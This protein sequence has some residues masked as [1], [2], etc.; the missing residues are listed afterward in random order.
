[1]LKI[2]KFVYKKILDEINE[3][4]Q[5]Q[6]KFLYD[7]LFKYLIQQTYFLLDKDEN[8]IFE[9]NKIRKNKEINKNP[10]IK[11]IVFEK[12]L[13]YLD[14]ENLSNGFIYSNDLF[15]ELEKIDYSEKR[16]VLLKLQKTKTKI[17]KKYLDFGLFKYINKWLKEY[18]DISVEMCLLILTTIENFP[19]EKEM[20]QRQSDRIDK[21]IN[22]VIKNAMSEEVKELARRVKKRWKEIL[23]DDNIKPPI[24]NTNQNVSS[25]NSSKS[26][27]IKPQNI[28]LSSKPKNVIINKELPKIVSYKP[29]QT[30]S[31]SISSLQNKLS[32]SSNIIDNSTG[33]K[34]K[35]E[36]EGNKTIKQAKVVNNDIFGNI[37]NKTQAKKEVKVQETKILPIPPSPILPKLVMPIFEEKKKV[38][39]IY[40]RHLNMFLGKVI[41]NYVNF[42]H[43]KMEKI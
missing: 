36:E 13:K 20:I 21:S 9:E 28:V 3:T 27:V 7:V 26:P 22:F 30:E 1:M 38:L 10:I 34:R 33:I 37:L 24:N 32:N 6:L 15:K 4:F 43:Q 35:N 31:V 18:N 40:Y 17:I 12:F 2:N 25:S 8:I 41:Q 5:N 16:F 14:D 23:Y 29:K 11:E 39:I 42:I 19:I